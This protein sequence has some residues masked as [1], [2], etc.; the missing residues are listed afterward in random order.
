MMKKM[1]RV[2]AL[3]FVAATMNSNTALHA[4][5]DFVFPGRSN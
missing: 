2:F 3:C 4:E 5:D 1:I